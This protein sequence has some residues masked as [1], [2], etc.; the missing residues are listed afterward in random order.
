MAYYTAPEGLSAGSASLTT[1]GTTTMGATPI[2][3]PVLI[4]NIIN[5]LLGALG[6]IFVGLIIYAG[7]LYFTDAGGE[8][9]AKKAKEI[10]KTAIVGMVIIIAAYAISNYVMGAL[11]GATTT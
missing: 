5:V 11:V 4:G 1:V 8:K 3:L 9:G 7:V 6:I 10:L 2:E